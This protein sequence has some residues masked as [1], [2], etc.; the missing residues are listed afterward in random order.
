MAPSPRAAARTRAGT[1]FRAEAVSAEVSAHASEPTAAT[2]LPPPPRPRRA[3]ADAPTQPPPPPRRQPLQAVVA[4]VAQAATGLWGAQHGDRG[5]FHTPSAGAAAPSAFASLHDVREYADMEAYRAQR[6]GAGPEIPERVFHAHFSYLA[7]RV[8]AEAATAR[9]AAA[10]ADWVGD[11]AL[12]AYYD[13]GAWR[14]FGQVEPPAAEPAPPALP[15]PQVQLPP[16]LQEELD[17]QRAE[18]RMLTLDLAQ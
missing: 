4:T 2:S 1:I 14:R 15:Q 13:A 12:G 17:R 9:A 6:H 11:H 3:P 10:T 16:Q 18:L 5:S 8:G 7:H